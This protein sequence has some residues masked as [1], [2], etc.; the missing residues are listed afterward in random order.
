MIL[1]PQVRIE[2]VPPT[3]EAGSLNHWTAREVPS[4]YHF[5]GAVSEPGLLQ[6]KNP[7]SVTLHRWN[8]IFR[9][10]N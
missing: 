10:A 8:M 4:F 2:P 6:P 1:V 5:R 7:S 9:A 3:G